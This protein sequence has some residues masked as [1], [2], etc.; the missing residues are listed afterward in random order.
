M[1][2]T[3]VGVRTLLTSTL[4][5]RLPFEDHRAIAARWPEYQRWMPRRI[6]KQPRQRCRRAIEKQSET[7]RGLE[8][9]QHRTVCE[10]DAE[11]DGVRRVSSGPI[12]THSPDVGPARRRDAPTALPE[13]EACRHNDDAAEVIHHRS[14]FQLLAKP[15]R[16][17]T[18]E[19]AGSSTIAAMLS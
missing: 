16:P 19:G 6:W 9:F 10:I 3:E 1:S 15:G 11:A 5:G 18:W 17:R 14:G 8:E 2:G 12:G 13:R 4:R 7:W